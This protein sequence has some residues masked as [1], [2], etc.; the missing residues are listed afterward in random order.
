MKNGRTFAAV[1]FRLP[2]FL[3]RCWPWHPW[4][5]AGLWVV[6]QVFW[7]WKL[8][9][10]RF[11]SDSL[12]Y[13]QYAQGIATR[14]E[15][16]PGHNAR[17]VLYPLFQSLWLKLGLGRGGMVAGQVLLSGLATRSL[18]GATR[19]LVGGGRGA[20]A[21]ATLAFIA[22]PDV[23][24]FNW[25][26][27][28]ESLFISLSVLSFGAF[29]RLRTANTPTN[30]AAL[31]ALLTLAA[32]ARPNGFVLALAALLAGLDAL[33]RQRDRRA[34]RGALLALVLLAPL[35]WAALN[36]QL[37]T[38]T[39]LE[40]YVRGDVIFLSPTWAV[41]SAGPLA[42]PPPTLAPATKVL[43]FAAHNP[44]H[45]GRL[46]VGKFFAFWSGLKPHY[47]PAHR[48]LNVLLLWPAYGLALR[49]A[50]RRGSW[51]PGRVFLAAVLGLQTAIILLTVDDW[52]V[53]FLAPVLFAVFA[54]AA[55]EAVQLGQKRR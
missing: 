31:L 21:L 44:A 50:A 5:L 22:W 35:A 36:R 3:R 25:Y 12:R 9:G 45:F 41:H 19:R 46:L 53:R 18:Y 24:P 27:L 14:G 29:V 55:V 13:L 48:L 8:H 1:P 32:L 6:A 26:L 7:G 40:T 10:P 30:W 52:D 37:A 11:A 20:A 39:L 23:Q 16:E 47:S 17:Y 34:W 38:Y 42:L 4:L 51:R 49:G 43:W 28:T 33:R 2:V 54:L 15:F